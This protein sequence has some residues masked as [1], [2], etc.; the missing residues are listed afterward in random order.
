MRGLPTIPASGVPQDTA[1][2]GLAC[3]SRRMG[4]DGPMCPMK[5]VNIKG[6]WYEDGRQL[7]RRRVAQ[8]LAAASPPPE[9]EN[10]MDQH[11]KYL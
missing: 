10:H 2:R 7:D 1:R 8:R 4:P 6:G 11:F 9:I 3:A 5:W